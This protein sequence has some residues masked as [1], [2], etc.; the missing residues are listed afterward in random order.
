LKTEITHKGKRYSCDLSKPLD[1]SIPLGQVNCFHAPKAKAEPVKAENFIGSVNKGA[2]VNFFN[3]TMNPHGNGTHTECIGHIT[4]DQESIYDCMSQYHFIAKLIS[5][6]LKKTEHGDQII[7]AQE[8]KTQFQDELLEALIIRTLPNSNEKLSKNYSG[9][10]PPY[11]SEQAMKYIVEKGVVHL[12]LDLPSVDREEDGGT[13][14]N[15]RLFWNTYGD[16]MEDSSH[17]S[18]T[19]TELIY[20][21]DNIKDGLYLVNIQVPSFHLDAAPSKP[22]LYKLNP[23]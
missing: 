9:T 23:Q 15:H 16:F 20:V 1:I 6:E 22:V 14:K 18:H 12:L 2:P 11:L 5:V 19:I 7:S 8:L 3:I 10:N 4:K 17:K 21:P 13:I